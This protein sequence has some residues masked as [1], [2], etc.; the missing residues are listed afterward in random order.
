MKRLMKLPQRF[1]IKTKIRD[2]YVALMSV[3]ILGAVGGIITTTL[4]LTGI[5]N[6]QSSDLYIKSYQAKALADTCVESAIEKIITSTSTTGTENIIISYGVCT[7]SITN[8]I[9]Q[10]KYISS[11]ANVSDVIR[12]VSVIV[13]PSQVT[14]IHTIK[15]FSWQESL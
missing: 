3:I 7:F 15:I 5:E 8:G 13:D 14:P 11:I 10:A 12:K 1:A 4:Y 6:V 2:G 9:G